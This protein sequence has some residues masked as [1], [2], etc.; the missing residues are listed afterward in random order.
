MITQVVLAV[1]LAFAAAGDIYFGFHWYASHKEEVRLTV[2]YNAV[3][4]NYDQCK[5]NQ[6]TLSGTIQLQDEAIKQAADAASQARSAASAAISKAEEGQRSQQAEFNRQR[7]AAR[8]G[9]NSTGDK[10]CGAA[11]Q[12]IRGTL[13]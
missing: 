13:K 9:Q 7:A 4:N 10:S 1:L 12:E 5:Q 8:A 6:S 3:K 2:D 11:I